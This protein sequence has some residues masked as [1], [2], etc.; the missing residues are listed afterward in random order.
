MKKLNI[1]ASLKEIQLMKSNKST[2]G[3]LL[4]LARRGVLILMF[5]GTRRSATLFIKRGA[6][7]NT[8]WSVQRVSESQ[9]RRE[10][11]FGKI[12]EKLVK[13]VMGLNL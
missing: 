13:S 7:L 9:R 3:W 10:W 4:I 8:N 2:H 6:R 11:D 12:L 1:R 5:P